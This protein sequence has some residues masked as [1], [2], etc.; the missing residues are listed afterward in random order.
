VLGPE[1]ALLEMLLREQ[2]ANG[3]AAVARLPAA[4]LPGRCALRARR[5]LC[6]CLAAGTTGQEVQAD[7]TVVTRLRL[8][9]SRPALDLDGEGLQAPEADDALGS[10]AAALE[11]L[12]QTWV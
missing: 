2:V 10:W 6:H 11:R 8:D 4:Q 5:S 1:R 12:L 9:G 3:T 7:A